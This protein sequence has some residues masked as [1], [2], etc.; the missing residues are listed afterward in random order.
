[1]LSDK[2]IKKKFKAE[3]SKNPEKYYAVAFLKK[4]GFARKRCK[5]GTHFWTVNKNQ[6]LCGDPACSGGYKFIEKSPVKKKMDYIETWQ[7][8]SK[9]MQGLGYTEIKRYPVVARWREDQ[10][11][12]GA[13]IY[14]FQPHVVSGEI[15]PPANP[16]IVPQFCLRFND[17]DNVGITGA[18]YTGFIMIGQHMFVPKKD[19]DQ[20]KVFSDI[21]KWLREGLGLPNKEITY[22]E[23]AWAG[24][25]NFGPC[26]EYF[27]RGLELGNQVYMLY[28]KTPSG[29]KELKLKVLDMG[30]GHERNTWFAKG[31]STSYDAVFPTV[32]NNLYKRT[33]IRLD[34]KLITRFLPYSSWL[35]LDE[36]EDIDK[37]WKRVSDKIGIEAKELK[38]KLLPLAALYSVGEHSRAALFAINDGALPSNV[39][40][41][42]NLRVILRRALSFIDKYKWDVSLNEICKWHAEYLKP[43]FPELIENI[44]NV[45]K[46]LD[47]EKQ[48][49]ISTKEK[50]K[51][52]IAQLIS[53]GS[54]SDIKLVQ[55]YDSHGISPDMVQEQ[56]AQL[57][58]VINYPDNF[59]ARVAEL[60][61]EAGHVAEEQDTL[62]LRDVED[63]EILYYKDFS[64]VD[65]DAVVLK[66]VGNK[67]ILNKTAFYPT[68][69]GQIHD[70]G[71]L[72]G[73]EVMSVYKQGAVVVHELKNKPRFK[74]GSFI[75]GKINFDRR[76]QLSQHHTATHIINGAARRVLG[77]HIWQAGA[78]KELERA[79]LDIT[80]YQALD[81]EEIS[82]IEKLSN[83]I[84]DKNLPVYSEILDRNIAEQKYGFRIYQGGAV[85][86][87]QLRIVN[88]VGFDVEACGGTHLHLTGEAKLIKILKTTK[89]QDG[90][91]RI[92]FAAG[93]AA[94]HYIEGEMNVLKQAA[95]ILECRINQV[96]GRAQE[97]FDKW[98]KVVKK[99]QSGSANDFKLSSTKEEKGGLLQKTAGILKTQ[100]EHVVKTLERFKK[101]LIKKKK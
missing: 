19:W 67:I 31:T 47:V 24:G 40:G 21:H 36:V 85:P 26:M 93:D 99:K 27:S 88:I 89:I 82:D 100:T 20:N 87:K 59:Y 79:R 84:I 66:I 53:R 58:V 70:K 81:E 50:S 63:T 5:C 75:R 2:D 41:G 68:S 51:Q 95:L 12:V 72:G 83:D 94:A 42:Y 4:E 25:G 91:V 55:L 71:T 60:H 61:K 49:Y 22:H 92:E 39:G 52:L 57:D 10:Y 86:G 43:L 77:E 76:L 3:A 7:K 6:A 37:A 65:F 74:T 69:G 45:S 34:K 64:L 35:N 78:H 48:K 9:L 11:W 62:E 33:G 80:H 18:H 96:P 1:M 38:K 97:L 73:Q 44:E 15:Q 17:I 28:E 46:I 30:M 32:C 56:A 29:R 16:L 90:I 14:D 101:E 23:D 98:K 13:S 8:F 54:I